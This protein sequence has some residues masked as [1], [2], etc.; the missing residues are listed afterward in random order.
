MQNMQKNQEIL[1]A[2]GILEAKLD[3][4]PKASAATQ[5]T[6]EPMK[7]TT[8]NV[9]AP[10]RASSRLKEVPRPNYVDQELGINFEDV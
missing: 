4:T 9:F 10:M 5:N 6:K 7:K 3:S 2:M 1:K 8:S